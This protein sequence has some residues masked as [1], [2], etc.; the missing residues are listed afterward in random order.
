MS[1]ILSS[2][3][4]RLNNSCS[5]RLSILVPQTSQGIDG[6]TL[7]TSRGLANGH[8]GRIL[9]EAFRGSL[10]SDELRRDGAR[11]LLC[12]ILLGGRGRPV[13]QRNGELRGGHDG[14]SGVDFSSANWDVGNSLFK[15]CHNYG[16]GVAGD[17]C[18]ANGHPYHIEEN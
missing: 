9:F 2:L 7:A 16:P 6:G 18:G 8:V 4:E 15:G 3:H 10:P 11:F 14:C 12:V 1:L 5:S 17:L 13:S